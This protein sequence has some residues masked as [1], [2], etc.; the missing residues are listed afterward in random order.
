MAHYLDPV[1]LPKFELL[2]NELTREAVEYMERAA[3]TKEQLDAYD[4]W[5]IDAM[6]ARGALND[7]R[8]EGKIEGKIEVAKNLLKK[9]MSMED[10]SD[11]TGLSKKQ[12]GEF[13]GF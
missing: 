5:K 9:G 4:Q 10:V 3:Y 6:T 1:E 12:I 7:A 8:K 13:V 2:D 11:A